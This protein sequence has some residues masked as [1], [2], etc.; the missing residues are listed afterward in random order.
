MKKRNIAVIVLVAALLAAGFALPEAVLALRDRR[1]EERQE[2]VAVDTTPVGA[3]AA[4]LTREDKLGLAGAQG[5]TEFVPLSTGAHMTQRAAQRAAE[6]EMETIAKALR[7]PG[8]W[9]CQEAYPMLAVGTDGRSFVVWRSYIT[10]DGVTGELTLDDDTESVLSY[11]LYG[12]EESKL[13]PTPEEAVT[14]T[15]LF[16]LALT[17]L[18]PLG[19]LPYAAEPDGTGGLVL[20]EGSDLTVRITVTAGNWPM[21]RVNCG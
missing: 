16:D 1:L 17:A 4:A 19:L 5:T 8:E 15:E 6:K 20:V 13:D 9:T 18:E 7:I 2:R 14:E 21:L 3:L 10:A 11:A 12:E